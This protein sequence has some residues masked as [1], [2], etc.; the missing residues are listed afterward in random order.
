MPLKI[1][2]TTGDSIVPREIEYDFNLMFTDKK[3]LILAYPLELILAEKLETVVSRSVIY[4][5]SRDFYDIYVLY[6]LKS[7]EIRWDELNKAIVATAKKRETLEEVKAYKEIISDIKTA[8]IVNSSWLRY[9]NNNM[10]AQDID[11]FKTL[12]T[13]QNIF[14]KI[15][16]V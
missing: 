6:Q 11:L 5:R 3:V 10:Y 8:E 2:F 9:Q 1:D 7:K 14:D 12:E 4:T 13:T 16:E 15:F